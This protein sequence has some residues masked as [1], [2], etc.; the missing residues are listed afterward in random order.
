MITNHTIL[1]C[2]IISSSAL[3]PSE[4]EKVERQI[5]EWRQEMSATYELFSRVVRGDFIEC[6]INQ[7]L[8]ALRLALLLKT[9]I[10]ASGVF[11]DQ[12]TPENQPFL[13]HGIRIAI[14]IGSLTRLQLENGII[15]GN[16]IH[17]T[18][19]LLDEYKTHDLQKVSVKQSLFF[20]SPWEQL[21]FDLQPHLAW[22]H[23]NLSRCTAKQCEV[24][25]LKLL[26]LEEKQIQDRLG[27]AQSTINNH[28]TQSGWGA[29]EK[30]LNWYEQSIGRYCKA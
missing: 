29:V 4:K 23:D 6:Y 18:G 24:L 28:T 22:L 7:P 21:N 9:S 30:T 14:G 19:R 26:G 16:I 11:V 17:Q 27:K 15:D 12:R 5:Q 13:Q 10:K 20:I 2:D 8:L 25:Y 1:S 3:Q